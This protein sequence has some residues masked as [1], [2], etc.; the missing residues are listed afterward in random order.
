MGA[1]LP[2]EITRIFR[3]LVLPGQRVLELGCA[4]GDLLAALEPAVG[5]G[6]DFSAEMIKS[7]SARHPELQF[8]NANVQDLKLKDTFDVIILSDLV[9]DLWMSSRCSKQQLLLPNRTPG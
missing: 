1:V 2:P 5:V 7:A 8:I 6:V 9:N 4:Y 3:T